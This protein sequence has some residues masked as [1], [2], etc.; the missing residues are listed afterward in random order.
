MRRVILPQ[1][2]KRAI[3]ALGN[4]FIIGLKD[5][6]LVA[7]LGVLRYMALPLPPKQRTSSPLRHSSLLVS[8][9]WYW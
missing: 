8:I 2:F 3:P 1:A 5:S 4:Q 9:T 6:S 7:Y